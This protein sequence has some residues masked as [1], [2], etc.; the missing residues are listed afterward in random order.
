MQNGFFHQTWLSA[1]IF[2]RL[3]FFFVVISFL[4]CAPIA[5]GAGVETTFYDLNKNSRSTGNVN[6]SVLV[7]DDIYFV[8]TEELLGNRVFRKRAGSDVIEQLPFP[9]FGDHLNYHKYLYV[10]QNQLYIHVSNHNYP[11]TKLYRFDDG[12]DCLTQ[13]ATNLVAIYKIVMHPNTM[14]FIADESQTGRELWR[15]DTNTNQ[16]RLVGDFNSDDSIWPGSNL[17]DFVISGDRIYFSATNVYQMRKLWFYDTVTTLLKQVTGINQELQQGQ[18]YYVPHAVAAGNGYVAVELEYTNRS[19]TKGGQLWLFKE[20]DSSVSKISDLNHY[21]YY[22]DGEG[23]FPRYIPIS[24][25]FYQ[26][27]VYFTSN[28][29]MTGEHVYEYDLTTSVK[30]KLTDDTIGDTTI[31]RYLDLPIF[32]LAEAEGKLYFYIQ[33]F[34]QYSSSV[35]S[36]DIENAVI[37]RV[38]HY[39]LSYF[40]HH[41]AFFNRSDDYLFFMGYER[42]RYVLS[43]LRLS[44][45][46]LV[47]VSTNEGHPILSPIV[48]AENEGLLIIGNGHSAGKQIWRVDNNLHVAQLSSVG[49]G[50]APSNPSLKFVI[51]DHLYFVADP[52]T[53]NQLGKVSVDGR[54]EFLNLD[55]PDYVQTHDI[56]TVIGNEIYLSLHP[57]EYHKNEIWKYHTVDK[58]LSSVEEINRHGLQQIEIKAHE[59]PYILY[60]GSTEEAGNQLWVYNTESGTTRHIEELKSHRY[61]YFSEVT[62]ENG[63]VYFYN[64]HEYI[65]QPWFYDLN[66]RQSKQLT[67]DSYEHCPQGAGVEQVVILENTVFFNRYGRLLQ[68]D[69][70]TDD[71]QDLGC[72]ESIDIFADNLLLKRKSEDNKS[73]FWLLD[74]ESG[75]RQKLSQHNAYGDYVFVADEIH[76]L[77]LDD[78]YD[79]SLWSINPLTGTQSKLIDRDFDNARDLVVLGE[80]SYFIGYGN[81]ESIKLWKSGNQEAVL[82]FSDAHVPWVSGKPFAFAGDLWMRVSRMQ[83]EFYTPGELLRVHIN[84]D[85]KPQAVDLDFDGDGIADIAFRLPESSVW[86]IESSSTGIFTDTLFGLQATDIP[87]PGDYDGDGI[88]DIAVRRPS[89]KWWYVI[90]SSQSNF[91]SDRGDGIQRILLGLSDED[92][93]VP[94]DYDGDG[95]TDFAVRRPSKG[96]WIIRQSSTGEIVE[97]QFGTQ[98]SDIPVVGNFD[99]DGVDDVAFRR[100]SNNT[101]YIRN[102]SGGNYNSNRVDGIQRVVLGVAEEDVPIPADYDGDGITDMAVWRLSRQVFIIRLSN[103]GSI[104]ERWFDDV[105]DA[106]PIAADFDGDGVSDTSVYS[107]STGEW[108]FKLSSTGLLRT[109]EFSVQDRAFPVGVPLPIAIDLINANET[110]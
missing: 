55:F 60:E 9:E 84:S 32:D 8:A 80:S 64:Y 2:Y 99:G 71:V 5:Y 14:F 89:S 18:K 45:Q 83:N 63:H 24:V 50:N 13:V 37:E 73:L 12:C 86:S 85:Y 67:S 95:I 21:Y 61:T 96:L 90:N 6:A 106:F 17:D 22:D 43:A 23:V 94:A 59:A 27:N 65:L 31:S 108:I 1:F 49:P 41:S 36:Y 58:T 70:Q 76:F 54:H 66:T 15:L 3:N 93:P 110:K 105:A 38:V 33:D 52:G 87:V 74:V 102:S 82:N 7:G 34:A 77:A 35:W 28:E 79:K 97:E 109:R 20:D 40:S 47:P 98:T 29:D 4:I 25:F 30:S 78:N 107:Q 62:L 16:A 72:V 104:I 48:F 91:N 57:N 26:D 44:N 101:W 100:V 10:F 92:I 88:V 53:G 75:E 81:S 11:G 46:E 69:R 56:E 103:S 51:D 19:A 42:E 68:Y 39:S